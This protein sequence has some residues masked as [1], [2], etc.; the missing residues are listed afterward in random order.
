M[1]TFGDLTEKVL[2]R[3]SLVEGL[4]AQI[5][6]EPR[7]QLAI[8]HKF[9]TLFREY[10]WPQY[11]TEQE[12]YVLDGTSGVITGSL[13][14]KLN[15]WRDLQCIFWDGS[16]TPLPMAP[17]NVRDIDIGYPCIRWQATNKEKMFRILPATTVGNVWLSY[18]T[19][20]KQ[21]EEDD[22]E[23]HLDTQC[24]LLGTC[25]DVLEDDGTNPGATDK[26]TGLYMD[27]ISQVTR[28]FH[29][30]PVDVKPVNRSTVNRWW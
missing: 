19:Y 11:M 16:A 29:N 9:D 5:Y 30:I 6:A 15:D 2:Q 23:I 24:M 28:M 21:F 20:P 18:R 8:Q 27:A 26:F 4:D 10:W 1:I 17:K 3:L 7:I 13:E 14:D 12:Q 25:A 22:E